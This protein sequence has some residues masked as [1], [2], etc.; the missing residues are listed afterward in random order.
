M[1]VAGERVEW[2]GLGRGVR[3]DLSKERTIKLSPER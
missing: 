2:E 1:F 3:K